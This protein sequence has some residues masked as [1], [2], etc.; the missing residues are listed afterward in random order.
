MT[1]LFD[2]REEFGIFLLYSGPVASG[3]V[4]TI[5]VEAQTMELSI[6]F[7]REHLKFHAVSGKVYFTYDSI[8]TPP[9]SPDDIFMVPSP[10]LLHQK[11]SLNIAIALKTFAEPEQLGDVFTAPVD[12]ILSSENV[13]VTDIIFVSDARKSILSPQ[14]VHGIPD[15]VV[16]ILSQNKDRDLVQKNDCTSHS[17]YRNIGSSILKPRPC[18]FIGLTR[19][20]RN[21]ANRRISGRTPR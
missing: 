9:E 3:A 14:N 4:Q 19:T 1:F 13:V 11:V 6:M 8:A 16:D 2:F 17:I 21:S 12:L 18:S 10:R 15:L 20:D 7:D 5:P